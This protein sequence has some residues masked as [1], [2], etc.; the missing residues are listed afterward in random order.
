MPVFGGG[1]SRFQPVYAGDVARFISLC[2][3]A[4]SKD[5]PESQ[6]S[7][8]SEAAVQGKVFECGGPD[9]AFFLRQR[10]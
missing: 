5:S 3:N 7:T 4:G 2:V 8:T 9:G 6:S 10:F 1:T